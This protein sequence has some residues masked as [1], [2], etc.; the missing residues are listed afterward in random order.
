[1]RSGCPRLEVEKINDKIIAHNYG[2]GGSGWTLGPGSATY[3]LDLLEKSCPSLSKETPI[4]IIGAGVIGLFSAYFALHKGYKNLT[5]IADRYENLTSHI[6]GGLLAPVSM[7]ND[8]SFKKVIAKIGIDAYLFY[9]E[10]CA[11]RNPILK[12]G[13]D[14]MPA[15]FLTRE[16]SGLEPYVGRVMSPAKNVLV[17]FGNAQRAMIVYDE[18]IF[19]HT[20]RMMDYLKT[21]LTGKVTFVT[22]KITSFD[23]IGDKH[24][25][26]CIGLGAEELLGD[27]KMVPVQGHLIV[28]KDQEPE[29]LQYMM[30]CHFSDGLNKHGQKTTRSLYFFPKRE[31]NASMANMGLLGGTFVVGATEETENTEEFDIM[32]NSAKEFF[33]I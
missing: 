33:G 29:K 14:M 24:I 31:L 18:G 19:M 3:V 12:D 2:H 6:A 15:Y 5:I 4:T 20:H 1:M 25:I 7:N 9:K 17:D 28:L 32:V 11:R 8:T 23:E 26:N 30:L 16:E 13:A 10:V 22:K 27:T 21:Y